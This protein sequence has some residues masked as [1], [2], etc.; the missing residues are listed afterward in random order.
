MEIII[1]GSGTFSP[2]LK[3]TS[4][5]LII[6]IK[7]DPIL[8]D[9]GSGIYFKLAH[10]GID[11]HDISNIFYTHYEHPDHVHDLPFIIF[12]KKYDKRENKKNLLIGGPAGLRNFYN[13]FSKIYSIL[14]E[15][16]FKLTIKEFPKE[17]FTSDNF[18]IK[19]KPMLHGNTKCIGYRIEAEGKSVVYSGDTDYCENVVSLAK[20]A[21]V[22]ITECSFPDELKAPNH[23][24]PASAGR[25]AHEA[26]VNT[27]VLTH[28]F[29]ECDKFNIKKQAQ[30]IF[31]G[32]VIIAKDLMRI[33]V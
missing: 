22:L 1:L 25:I 2:S 24:A 14:E 10:A 29:P 23:L 31:K 7:K 32:K 9:S 28:L 11:F 21:D 30:K 13:M 6:K 3:R 33:K 8:F 17:K 5:G 4:A 19:T 18:S 12:A 26:E 15:L 20:N 27:L 16:P